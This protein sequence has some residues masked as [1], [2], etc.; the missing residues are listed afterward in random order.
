M[1]F[2]YDLPPEII[3]LQPNRFYGSVPNANTRLFKPY[4]VNKHVAIEKGGGL[5][6]MAVD[7]RGM[8]WSNSGYIY[9]NT[10][11]DCYLFIQIT[12]SPIL[13]QGSAVHC[14][15]TLNIDSTSP[16]VT[17][18]ALYWGTNIY[19]SLIMSM[20][21]GLLTAWIPPQCYYA[22]VGQYSG[23]IDAVIRY[24][25]PDPGEAPPLQ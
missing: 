22:L 9:K 15:A 8:E 7:L 24:W 1:S 3:A 18:A 5:L 13:Q 4:D 16:P 12:V 19:T 25:L 23:K 6:S 11:D 14:G 17:P 10:T 21:R 2:E 20:S